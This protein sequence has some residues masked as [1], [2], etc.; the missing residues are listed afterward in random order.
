MLPPT[1]Y[2]V[3]AAVTCWTTNADASMSGNS[4]AFRS[5]ST[6]NGVSG[7]YKLCLFFVWFGGL[8]AAP[9]AQHGRER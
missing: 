4:G 7:A 8:P 2:T 3:G 9:C 5:G 6:G 1:Q